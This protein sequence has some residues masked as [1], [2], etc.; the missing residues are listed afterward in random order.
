MKITEGSFVLFFFNSEKKWLAKVEKDKKLHTHLGIID[1]G[2]TIDQEFGSFIVTNKDKKIYLLPPSIYDFVMKS[3]RATQIVYPKDYGYIAARTGLKNGFKVVE[4]GTGSAALA[5]FIASIVMPTGHVYSFDVN[6][7]FMSIA[8]K[9]LERSQMDSVVTL[10]KYDEKKISEMDN[11]D[12]VIIDL[13]DPWLYLDVVHTCMKE[14]ASV[15]CICPTMNQLEKL[16]TQFFKS[17]FVD[18]E[19]IE[20]FVRRIEAR[21][22]KTRPNMRMIGHTTYLGF[23]RKILK[24]Y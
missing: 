13:G 20:T 14:G 5:T 9:N 17:G 12:L 1:V 21:E 15:V 3:Q 18:H 11:V 4:I 6:E 16:S 22:G 24:Q 10:S 19:Y 8:K 23:A 2:Y 7:D